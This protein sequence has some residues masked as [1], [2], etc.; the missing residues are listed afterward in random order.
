MIPT[1]YPLFYHIMTQNPTRFCELHYT[2]KRRGRPSVELDLGQ[3][4][5]ADAEEE[6]EFSLNHIYNPYFANYII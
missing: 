6:D 5:A 4:F 2:E 1:I 3:D